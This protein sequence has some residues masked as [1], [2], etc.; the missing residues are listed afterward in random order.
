MNLTKKR[1]HNKCIHLANT[2]EQL[3]KIPNHEIKLETVKNLRTNLTKMAESYRK[4]FLRTNLYCYKNYI[5]HFISMIKDLD[6]FIVK[7]S[8]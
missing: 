2:A 5:R 8:K 6:K 3:L 4:L 7:I 1:L